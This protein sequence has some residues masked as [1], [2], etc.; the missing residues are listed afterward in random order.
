[1]KPIDLKDIINGLI[2]IVMLSLALGQYGRLRD[3]A[4]SEF[5]KSVTIKQQ[6]VGTSLRQYP[7]DKSK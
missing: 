2:T 3:F 6:K 4:K 5:L 1:M 7:T